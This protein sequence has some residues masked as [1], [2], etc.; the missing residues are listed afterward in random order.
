[1]SGGFGRQGIDQGRRV[2]GGGCSLERPSPSGDE[3]DDYLLGSLRLYLFP[4]VDALL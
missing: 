4:T 1:M 2:E 3:T